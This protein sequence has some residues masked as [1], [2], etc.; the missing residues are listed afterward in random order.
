MPAF[1]ATATT[2]QYIDADAPWTALYQI[3]LVP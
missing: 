2:S 1:K 3:E